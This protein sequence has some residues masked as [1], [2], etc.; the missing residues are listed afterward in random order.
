MHPELAIKEYNGIQAVVNRITPHIPPCMERMHIWLN[1]LPAETRKGFQ[2]Q[3][4][5]QVFSYIDTYGGVAEPAV[6]QGQTLLA[7]INRRHTDYIAD[8][9]VLGELVAEHHLLDWSPRTFTDVRAA[10]DFTA[11]HR[12]SIIFCKGRYG[13]AGEQVRCIKTSDLAS[14][15]LGEN[16][17]LQEAV[18]HPELYENRK[19]VFRVYVLIHNANLYYNDRFFAVI[20]GVDYDP[21]S[22]AHEI[23]VKH[24]GYDRPGS[25]IKL[26]P[27]HF[28]ASYRHYVARIQAL[29]CRAEPIFRPIVAESSQSR[30]ML[31][32]A[33]MI[34]TVDGGMKLIE[35]NNYP[36]M[37]HTP[38]VNAEVNIP[39]ITGVMKRV[40][41]DAAD[42]YWHPLA[43][44]Q[45]PIG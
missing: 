23:Q 20:H 44:P 31:L 1:T 30:Y 2:E 40:L 21:D 32:G 12:H 33:D 13:T 10:A 14:F 8:K 4:H 24:S 35:V 7:L 38:S 16:E 25:P 11:N 28:F 19:M 22:D 5:H 27:V 9:R 42:D 15:T 45:A 17:I 6:P 39:M 26:V 41:F 37:I 3:A 29:L 34:P 18:I 36:N 43:L